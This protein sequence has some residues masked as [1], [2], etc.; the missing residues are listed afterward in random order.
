MFLRGDFRRGS[1]FVCFLFPVI[2]LAVD[3]DG[4]GVDDVVDVCCNTPGGIAVDPRGRPIGDF[5][6]DCD[7]DTLDFAEFQINL[8]GSMESGCCHDS[9]CH[10]EDPCTV[11]SCNVGTGECV[12]QAR[13]DCGECNLGPE[14]AV[15]LACD[16][17]LQGSIDTPDE[18]DSMCFCA[19]ESELVRLSV[20]RGPGSSPGFNPNWRLVDFL[21]NP[22]VSCGTFT[23]SAARVCGPLPGLGSPYH[24]EVID[25]SSDDTGAYSV[26]M[27]RYSNGRACDVTP[28]EC[29][30]PVIVNIEH[31]LDT[32]LLSFNVENSDMVRV[33]IAP[34]PGSGPVFNASWRLLDAAGNAPRTCGRTSFLAGQDCGPLP[35]AGNPYRVEIEDGARDD[36]GS[37]EVRL[38]RTLP[39]RRCASRTIECDEPIFSAIETNSDG[40]TYPFRVV[41]GEV[42]RVSFAKLAGG[43]PVFTPSWRV[44]DATGNGFGGCGIFASTSRSACGPLPAAGNP[45]A[46]QVTDGSLNDT[47]PYAVQFHRLTSS[48]ACDQT[49]LACGVPHLD[50]L[51]SVV[52]ANL[53][54][55]SV[56]EQET[57]R[58]ALSIVN[59]GAHFDLE[60]RLID[61]AGNPA[62][63]C[64][65]F[66]AAATS[67]CPDLPAYRNPY[68]VE[69]QDVFRDGAGDYDVRVDFLTSGCP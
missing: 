36:V 52:D 64:G 68:R 60:W 18:T 57:V 16:F 31:P 48:R 67:D 10:D 28:L 38:E 32:D 17:P 13:E 35:A 9:D 33:S 21:G 6:L 1:L 30:T 53:H 46:I 23:T 45:Y 11:D 66:T 20:L 56:P 42:V 47:G 15:E 7:V 65:T 62:P 19:I 40:Q 3:T 61:A 69:V 34:L 44:I 63:S 41:E 49:D 8:T 43:G 2:A 12:F 27:Q 39:H 51:R 37:V 58:V 59:P 4:D 22:T 14:C 26:H 55:F 25:G 29:D 54:A 5:D 50:T 24:V